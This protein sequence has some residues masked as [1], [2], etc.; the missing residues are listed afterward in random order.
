[1]Y[2]RTVRA[3]LLQTK[4]KQNTKNSPKTGQGG[5]LPEASSA[6]IRLRKGKDAANFEDGSVLLKVRRWERT[7]EGLKHKHGSTQWKAN[8]CNRG[9]NDTKLNQKHLESGN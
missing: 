2:W 5:N 7:L 8:I 6:D 9:V 3:F 1:L 4:A